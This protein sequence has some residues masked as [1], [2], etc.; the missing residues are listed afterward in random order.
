MPDARFTSMFA[1]LTLIL[2]SCGGTSEWVPASAPV[3][4]PF[5]A[6]GGVWVTPSRGLESPV[7][8]S[9][10]V[11]DPRSPV[12]IFAGRTLGYE[13]TA[14]GHG[15]FRFR[16]TTDTLVS[17]S[18]ARRFTGSVSTRG[19][20]ASLVPGCDDASCALEAG[21]YV[22]AVTRVPGGGERID[23]DTVATD[24]WDGFSFTVADSEPL[25]FEVD[26]DGRARPELLD[27]VNWT[28]PPD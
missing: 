3:G 25:Y 15:A 28:L 11:P 4:S 6:S 7:I 19:H 27:L 10:S 21:D 5:M 1:A 23:W 13:L 17:H 14:K 2:S 9:P 12:K 24:G 16:W 18:G 26:V 22:S 20:F 8:V